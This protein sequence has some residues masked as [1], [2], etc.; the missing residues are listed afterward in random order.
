LVWH[1][2]PPEHSAVVAQSWKLV[3]PVAQGEAWQALETVKVLSDT[4]PQQ[5]S[6]L[7][8]VLAFMHVRL[9]VTSGRPPSGMPPL[10]LDEPLL[11]EPPLLLLPSASLLLPLPPLVLEL[12]AA[13]RVAAKDAPTKNII[14]FILTNLPGRRDCPRDAAKLSSLLCHGAQIPPKPA[15][16]QVASGLPV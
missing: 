16:G 5:T 9:T 7:V 12:Q 6:G 4:D 10:P 3:I 15:P 13:A 14:L 11:D 2:S 1:V 8:Q